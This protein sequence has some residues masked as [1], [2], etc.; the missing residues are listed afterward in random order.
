MFIYKGIGSDRF[1]IHLDY[2][3]FT[4]KNMSGIDRELNLET[5][6]A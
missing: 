6:T 3:K 4:R 2:P 1:L 5:T